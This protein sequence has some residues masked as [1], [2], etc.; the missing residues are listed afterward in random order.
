MSIIFEVMNDNKIIILT[1]TQWK[2][3]KFRHPEMVNKLYDIEKTIRKPHYKLYFDDN[4]RKYYKYIKEETKYIMVAIKIINGEGF[5]ITSYLT[6][7]IQ[8]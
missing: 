2:H 7:R 6:S 5:V 8:K 4:T 1:E 3:I